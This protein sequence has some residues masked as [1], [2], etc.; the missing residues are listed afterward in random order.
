MRSALGDTPQDSTETLV[1]DEELKKIIARRD[2]KYDG[3]FYFGVKTTLIYCRPTCPARP[4]PENIVIFKSVTE[5]EAS[6]FRPCLRCRPD[7]APGSKVKPKRTKSRR[8]ILSRLK[9]QGRSDEPTASIQ[10][11]LYCRVTASWVA[12]AL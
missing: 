11:V 7:V 10:L 8:F 9:R 12:L 3:R 5:A 6:G 1:T 4:N 2:R